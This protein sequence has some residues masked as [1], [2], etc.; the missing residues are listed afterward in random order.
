VNGAAVGQL[1]VATAPIA[2]GVFTTAGQAQ[3]LHADGTLASASHPAAAGETLTV[4]A[5]GLGPV[6][7]PIADGAASSDAVRMVASTPVFI[8][9]VRCD[10]TFAGLSSTL[11]GVNQLS[12]VVPAGV[13]GIVPLVMNAGGIIS[14]AAVTVAIQ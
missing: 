3:A 14:T 2:P 1:S 8:G 10:V 11:L 6:S 7:P 4:Y 5:N 13:H 9:G 12:V